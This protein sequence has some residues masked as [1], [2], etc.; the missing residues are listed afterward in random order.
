MGTETAWSNAYVKLNLFDPAIALANYLL[1]DPVTNQPK[2]ISGP[3]V[4]ATL[5]RLGKA[6]W[7]AFNPIVPRSFRSRAGRTPSRRPVQK[8]LVPLMCRRNPLDLGG[9]RLL[10]A[11]ALQPRRWCPPRRP[12]PPPSR[13]PRPWETTT[14]AARTR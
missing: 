14:T 12:P 5:D 9:P 13:P 3:E 2:P 10:R 1:A 8:P 7:L 11:P 6:L 4:A